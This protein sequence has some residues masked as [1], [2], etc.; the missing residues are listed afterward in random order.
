MCSK[1]GKD[2]NKLSL[3]SLNAEYNENF[4]TYKEA[5]LTIICKKL[6]GQDLNM[7][8]MSEEIKEKYYSNDPVHK[9]YIGEVIDIIDR[10]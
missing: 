8:N 3:T 7:D 1:S 2:I 6:Y 9:M 10:R 4:V 5:V